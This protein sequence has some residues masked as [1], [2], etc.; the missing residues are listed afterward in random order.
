MVLSLSINSLQRKFN[1]LILKLNSKL[2]SHLAR[3]SKQ[4]LDFRSSGIFLFKKPISLKAF[5]NDFY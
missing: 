3:Q 5:S 1:K 2:P 4:H